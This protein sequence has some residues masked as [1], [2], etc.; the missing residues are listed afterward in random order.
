MRAPLGDGSE[1]NG[2]MYGGGSA[3]G[4]EWS[5]HRSN[6]AI[7]SHATGQTDSSPSERSA[8]KRVER[9]AER[10]AERSAL[11]GALRRQTKNRWTTRVLAADTVDCAA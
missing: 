1:L 4:S 6:D 7:S 2:E 9:S 10:I 8:L 3:K 11:S 5:N